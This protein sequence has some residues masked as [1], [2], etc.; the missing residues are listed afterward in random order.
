MA[1]SLERLFIAIATHLLTIY[2][3]YNSL[4]VDGAYWLLAIV[5]VL[6]QLQVFSVST[7]LHKGVTHG[8]WRFKSKFVEQLIVIYLSISGHIFP[9][10]PLD[11]AVVHRLHHDHL[12]DDLDSHSPSR[13]GMLAAHFHLWKPT[14][15]HA[16]VERKVY[17]DLLK[18]YRH[19][20]IFSRYPKSIAFALWSIIIVI[21]GIEGLSILAAA[22]FVEFHGLGV[23][24][25]YAHT[26]KDE[27]RNVPWY[28]WI[29]G[30]NDPEAMYHKEH[31]EH[32]YAYSFNPG[33]LDYPSRIMEL[34]AKCGIVDIKG[35][36]LDVLSKT[37]I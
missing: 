14:P 11:W 3:I 35:K 25:A 26:K 23:I 24:D 22:S 30:F 4:Y 9:G 7:F 29:I 5:F 27:T 37:K 31:H 20:W 19:L 33:W 16:T 34:F 12:D 10:G 8:V 18:N 36:K 28:V 17:F 15:E 2:F 21:F 6:F 1:I 32:P 13:I